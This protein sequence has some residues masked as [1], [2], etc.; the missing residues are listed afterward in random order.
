MLDYFNG[1][2]VSFQHL[3]RAVAKKA[4]TCLHQIHNLTI[5]HGDIYQAQSTILPNVM[6]SDE[7]EVWWIDLEHSWVGASEES[8]QDK[9]SLADCIWGSNGQVWGE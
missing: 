8:L 2:L 5:C 6:V 1:N 7:G 3:T 9:F 4:L